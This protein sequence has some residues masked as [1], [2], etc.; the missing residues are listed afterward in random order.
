MR[1][2]SRAVKQG[3]KWVLVH[4]SDDES[5]DE[6]NQIA[7]QDYLGADGEP[8]PGSGDPDGDGQCATLEEFE[9]SQG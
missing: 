7:C 6:A 2:P 8:V 9:A 1:S 5:G 3:G 4:E